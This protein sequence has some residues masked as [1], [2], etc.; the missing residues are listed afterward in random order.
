MAFA[1]PSLEADLFL[2]HYA[3]ALGA[4]PT[5]TA[6]PRRAL[7]TQLASQRGALADL[8]PALGAA[9][10]RALA[11]AAR[12][13]LDANALALTMRA[14]E[15]GTASGEPRAH[16]Y[17]VAGL[18]FAFA[19]TM[20]AAQEPDLSFAAMAGPLARMFEEDAEFGGSDRQIA[21]ALREAARLGAGAIVG[22]TH[23]DVDALKAVIRSVLAIKGDSGRR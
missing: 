2:L 8:T 10:D 11:S 21:K 1:G 23:V 16:G 20:A 13:D 19:M 6:E 9:I 5:L 22:Q 12:G 15:A 7:V 3:F 17:F 18:W 4:L 14:A